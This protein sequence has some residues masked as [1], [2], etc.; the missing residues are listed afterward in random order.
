MSRIYLWSL[1][2]LQVVDGDVWLLLGGRLVLCVLFDDSGNAILT[3]VTL[4][5]ALP[6]EPSRFMPDLQRIN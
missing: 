1:K 2:H 4:V 6:T 3:D 5:G